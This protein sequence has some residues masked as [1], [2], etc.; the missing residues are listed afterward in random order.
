MDYKLIGQD[1]VP[2]DVDAK[3]RGK[4][5]Y[6]EDMRV[7]GM[8]HC[9]LLTSPMPHARVRR[10]DAAAPRQLRTVHEL[11]CHSPWGWCSNH[12]VQY[13]SGR[14]VRMYPGLELLHTHPDYVSAITKEDA[15]TKARV[16]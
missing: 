8:L 11:R 10:I 13:S 12:A 4:A 2:P 3:V 16:I 1:F 9:K 6:T 15:F 7:E 5:R 14:Q